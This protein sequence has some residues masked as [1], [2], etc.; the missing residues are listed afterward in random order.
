LYQVEVS[1]IGTPAQKADQR[2]FT[3]IEL[4]VVIVLLGIL[5]VTALGR[6]QD[7]SEA[8][9]SAAVEG[10]GAQFGAGVNAVH[11]KWLADGSPGAVLNY[12]PVTS[13]SIP[14][15]L[16]VNANGWPADIRGTSLTLNSVFDCEDVWVAAMIQGPSISTTAGNADYQAV[17]NGSNACTYINQDDTTKDIRFDSNTG[18]VTINN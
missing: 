14:G 4:V 2:G 6:F 17:Y 13:S 9:L 16:S 12:L 8:A 10:T 11:F 1:V 7:M 5:G 3:L 18:I 15:S